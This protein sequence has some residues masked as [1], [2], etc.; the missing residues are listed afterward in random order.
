VQRHSNDPV[1]RDES[2][3][4]AIIEWRVERELIC[5]AIAS[6]P[7]AAFTDIFESRRTIRIIHPAPLREVVNAIAYATRPRFVHDKQ[8]FR[9]LRPSISAG[10]LHPIEILLIHPQGSLRVYHYSSRAHSLSRLRIH[11]LA[12]LVTFRERC[13]AIL[14]TAKGTI[15]ILIARCGLVEKHYEH[16]ASLCWRDAGALLQT[17]GFACAAFRLAFCPLG[18]L[19]SEVA[20][21]LDLHSEQNE[22]VG[23]AFIGRQVRD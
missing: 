20:D 2:L 18:I 23:A 15:V 1:P 11:K 10:A 19:G 9:S 13:H 17:L 4:T 8:E 21:A 14:P 3:Q 5:P 6:P 12:S 7:E 16:H 22:P